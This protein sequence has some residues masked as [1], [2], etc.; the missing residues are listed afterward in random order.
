MPGFA[1][2]CQK[3]VRLS[4]FQLCDSKYYFKRHILPDKEQNYDTYIYKGMEALYAFMQDSWQE[5][6]NVQKEW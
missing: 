2:E 3:T 1:F 4:F 5:R 6:D